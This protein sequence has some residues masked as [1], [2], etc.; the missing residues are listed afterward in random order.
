M[1]KVIKG[2]ELF[3]DIFKKK[4]VKLK[5][6]KFGISYLINLFKV[7]NF[8]KDKDVSLISKFKVT[9]AILIALIYLILGI[10]FIPEFLLGAFGFVDDLIVIIWSLEIVNNEIEK[11]KKLKKEIKN[12]NII[13]G[14]TFSIKD[15]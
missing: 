3:L 4:L 5:N 15:E 1:K 9:F 2:F 7:W 8:Y 11:Y 10:D 14:V 12:S 13:E 6:N